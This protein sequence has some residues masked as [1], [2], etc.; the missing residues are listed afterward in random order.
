MKP[1][2]TLEP[3]TSWLS[4][5]LPLFVIIEIEKAMETYEKLFIYEVRGEVAEEELP[6]S[7]DLIGIWLEG[8][9]SYIFFKETR[10]DEIRQWAESRPDLK[11][12]S[13]TVVDYEDWEAGKKVTHTRVGRFLICPVWDE[14]EE[15]GGEIRILLDP[16]VAFGTAHHSTTRMCLE[17]MERV[18]GEDPP[19]RVLDLGSGTGI[20]SIAAVRLGAESV[21]AVDHNGLAVKTAEKNLRLNGVRDRVSLHQGEAADFLNA[22]PDLLVANLYFSALR[23]L[24]GE[25]DFAAAK[26]HL[27]S[28]LHGGDAEQLLKPLEKL[29]LRL[30]ELK[31]D[32]DWHAMLLQNNSLRSTELRDQTTEK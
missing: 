23:E 3:A 15:A 13:E 28:G 17:L 2:S 24:A 9:Y 16:G 27:L 29:P 25:P 22:G 5:T 10:E 4:S 20:L 26:W 12:R 31:S 21:V 7:D 30:I 19:A 11:Y 32:G 1:G 14:Q 18:F 8:G 6:S